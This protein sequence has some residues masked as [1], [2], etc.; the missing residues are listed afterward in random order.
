VI[1]IRNVIHLHCNTYY[2]PHVNNTPLSKDTFNGPNV[3][4]RIYPFI[5]WCLSLLPRSHDS[6]LSNNSSTTSSTYNDQHGRVLE[7]VPPTDRPVEAASSF[8]R[9]VVTTLILG[10]SMLT[11]GLL[12]ASW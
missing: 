3:P 1:T 7:T 5:V 6:W 8:V 9:L 11:L 4:Q 2:K 12:I 10:L